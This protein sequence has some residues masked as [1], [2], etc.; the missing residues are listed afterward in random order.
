[1]CLYRRCT[2]TLAEICRNTGIFCGFRAVAA[3]KY[4]GLILFMSLFRNTKCIDLSP[5][6]ARC[7]WN[8]SRFARTVLIKCL[9]FF[10]NLD[11]ASWTCGWQNNYDTEIGWHQN[12]SWLST[13]VPICPSAVF[14]SI[15]VTSYS[16]EKKTGVKWTPFFTHS[17]QHT[18]DKMRKNSQKALRVDKVLLRIRWQRFSFNACFNLITLVFDAATE[19]MGSIG[20]WGGARVC[21]IVRGQGD[22]FIYQGIW[23]AIKQTTSQVFRNFEGTQTPHTHTQTWTNTHI[24]NLP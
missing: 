7:I 9:N 18:V 6:A 3:K 4:P 13:L 12:Q 20:R 23:T 19:E 5:H 11:W 21:N 1:M 2:Q 22:L 17:V 10:I 24:H 14:S 16:F 15:P 8:H